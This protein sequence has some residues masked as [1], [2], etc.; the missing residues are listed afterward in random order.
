[1]HLQDY[2]PGTK[3]SSS[4][5]LFPRRGGGTYHIAERRAGLLPDVR[6]PGRAIA[7][8][9]AAL[10][11]VEPAILDRETA[12]LVEHDKTWHEER[13]PILEDRV[14]ARL[15]ELS[16]RLAMPTGSTMRSAPVTYSADGSR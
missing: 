5:S 15:G 3:A 2:V 11:T 8:M 4:G 10:N 16:S 12:T 1:M 13:R 6:M 7:W 9:F 14:H